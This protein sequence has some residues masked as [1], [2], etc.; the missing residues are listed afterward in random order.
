GGFDLAQVMQDLF[1]ASPQLGRQEL[2]V[3]RQAREK[4]R[5]LEH[6][7]QVLAS[8]EK[9][10]AH[11]EQE[12]QQAKLARKRAQVYEALLTQANL[13]NMQAVHL[14]QLQSY[15][16]GQ[17]VV[18]PTD[19]RQLKDLM[20]EQQK[21]EQERD[22]LHAQILVQENERDAGA[23]PTGFDAVK[24]IEQLDQ[25]ID[26]ATSLDRDLI[27]L[28]RQLAG[29]E[30]ELAGGSE[31]QAPT[32]PVDGQTYSDL[33]DIHDH[34][35]LALSAQAA[36][37]DVRRRL[38]S[39]GKRL[40]W[41]GLIMLIA[42][43]TLGLAGP[44]AWPREEVVG[45]VI[46]AL[47]MALAIFGGFVLGRKMGLRE[48]AIGWDQERAR[49]QEAVTQVQTRQQELGRRL[50][51]DLNSP[52]LV[53]NLKILDLK[54]EAQ[55]KAQRW[56]QEC[57]T[58]A[59]QRDEVIA[60]AGQIL[61]PLGWDA[62]TTLA[63]LKTAA[64]QL[65]QLRDTHQQKALALAS[66]TSALDSAQ[67][68]LDSLAAQIKAIATRL[69]LPV[70]ATLF[71][72]AMQM[73]KDRPIWESAHKAV[74]HHDL[75]LAS[76]EKT[77][78]END[79]VVDLDAARR[80]DGKQWEQR[81][82]E[83]RELAAREDD[84]VQDLAQ[85]RSELKHARGSDDLETATAQAEDALQ[86]LA[87]RREDARD[88]ALG[89]LLLGEVRN[90][91]ET[92]SRPA[93][94]KEAQDLFNQFTR[95]KY[96]LVVRYDDGGQGSFLARDNDRQRDLQLTQLSDGTRAQ[97]LLAVRLGFIFQSESESRP[98]LFLDDS[99]AASDPVRFAAVSASLGRLASDR[100]RQVFF[101]TADPTEATAWNQALEQEGLPAAHLIDLGLLRRDQA[102]ALPEALTAA[103][104]SP[105]PAPDGL[106]AAEY[107]QTLRVPALDP[108]APPSET[109]LF[110]LL[111][112]QPTTLHQLLTVGLPTV[113]R[114]E[115]RPDPAAG[116]N[117]AQ[118]ALL[119]FRV[120]LWTLVLEAWR[121]GRA[122]P[123]TMETVD[124]S[125]A[126][127]AIMRPRVEPVLARCEG[128][129]RAF[130]AAIGDGE[131]QGL[132]QDKKNLL[133]EFLEQEGFLPALAPLDADALLQQ[134]RAR[135]LGRRGDL[136]LPA[137]EL[138]QLIL[139]QVHYLDQA[140]P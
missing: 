93:V 82:L 136:D 6:R 77:L 26:D 139:H 76:L 58:A 128:D 116:L 16:P 99:L 40:P 50:G 32:A 8:Q 107:G 138:R 65:T 103:V 17:D 137:E 10:L 88:Q 60:R 84:L 30:L 21:T 80:L 44:L 101:L 127:S 52:H 33:L 124:Q 14:A 120:N 1:P 64:R 42:G 105:V 56:R 29:H 131:V 102:A 73:V 75:Q 24:V 39:P 45:W 62:P 119:E 27:A 34:L 71:A 113:G 111:D 135:A 20:Q 36:A 53:F 133:Q 89:Q 67:R 12:V 92:R 72:R 61:H 74:Q 3:W 85:L 28:E 5:D 97:L 35:N 87:A 48:E 19:T 98:P 129:A 63:D 68:E 112:D 114:W 81:R 125:G 23:W 96:E 130:I 54:L 117:D 2:R 57:T 121:V 46:S 134:V 41:W 100:Q 31:N 123:L 106:T 108:W 132:R 126:I 78:K 91:S 11:L 59:G 22:R 69:Q 7:Y 66:T 49:R 70:D 86:S 94:L 51:L 104:P 109:H 47:G 43:A 4:V 115:N 55:A 95:G 140:S 15:P 110:Y 90:Q 13:K 9:G 118:H 37:E 79:Q 38:E 25:L 83:E 122:Q 18:L